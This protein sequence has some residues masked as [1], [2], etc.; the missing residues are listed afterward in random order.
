MVTD[1][2]SRSCW[3]LRPAVAVLAGTALTLVLTALHL[4]PPAAGP[5]VRE[6]RGMK[7]VYHPVAGRLDVLRESGAAW[8]VHR[9]PRAEGEALLNV[10]RPMAV[11]RER[12]LYH[13]P[14]TLTSADGRATG[15]E[16]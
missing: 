11:L 5:M 1:R 14:T 15:T 8:R 10:H 16:H 6:S 7:F 9:V 4:A 13:F 3:W 2:T 12:L